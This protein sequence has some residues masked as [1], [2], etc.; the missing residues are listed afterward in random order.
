[1]SASGDLADFQYISDRLDEKVRQCQL[2]DDSINMDPKEIFSWLNRILYYRRS[3]LNP[4]WLSI[5]VAGWSF[6]NNSNGKPFLSYIDMVNLYS[7][8]VYQFLLKSKQTIIY[9]II[10]I[11][12]KMN[13]TVHVSHFR[14]IE[15]IAY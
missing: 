8:A 5:I 1:M 14:T 13:C 11:Y 10:R 4:L 12:M 7:Y 9:E 15:T 6:D 2:I 3:Q